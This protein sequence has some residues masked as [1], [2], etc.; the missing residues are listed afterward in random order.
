M[1][2]R[3]ASRAAATLRLQAETGIALC[4]CCFKPFGSRHPLGHE[5]AEPRR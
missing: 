3:R 5:K 2:P 4:V 1:K